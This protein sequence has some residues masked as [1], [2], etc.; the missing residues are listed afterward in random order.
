MIQPQVESF[1]EAA[2]AEATET[3][4]ATEMAIIMEEAIARVTKKAMDMDMEDSTT[5]ATYSLSLTRDQ[6][7]IVSSPQK[8]TYHQSV[9]T[10]QR[11]SLAKILQ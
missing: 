11:G 1:V 4:E 6:A 7:V 5:M 10:T 9:P 3:M 2:M 8:K